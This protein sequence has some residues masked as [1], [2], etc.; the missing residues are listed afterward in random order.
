MRF[1]NDLKPFKINVFM[2]RRIIKKQ[3]ANFQIQNSRSFIHFKSST[4]PII[5]DVDDLLSPCS[6]SSTNLIQNSLFL[7]ELS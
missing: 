5:S 6:I 4:T 1:K 7:A 2:G 3:F